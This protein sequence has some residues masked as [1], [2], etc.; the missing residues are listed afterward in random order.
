MGWREGV[1]TKGLMN[2]TDVWDYG[3]LS[4]VIWGRHEEGI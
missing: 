2:G 1:I 3:L 4:G